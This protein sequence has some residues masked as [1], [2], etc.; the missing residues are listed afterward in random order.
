[1]VRSPPLSPSAISTS[2]CSYTSFVRAQQ[3][4]KCRRVWVRRTTGSELDDWLGDTSVIRTYR[5][6]APGDVATLRKEVWTWSGQTFEG[7]VETDLRVSIRGHVLD[8]N[9]PIDG[10]GAERDAPFDVHLAAERTAEQVRFV[11]PAPS[12]FR[13]PSVGPRPQLPSLISSRPRATLAY[14]LLSRIATPPTAG[15]HGPDPDQDAGPRP[16]V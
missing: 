9:V 1:M 15:V 4:V 11:W 6:P 12:P 5:L 7:I 3:Q 2:A 14:V 16:D 8:D 13:S 10:H